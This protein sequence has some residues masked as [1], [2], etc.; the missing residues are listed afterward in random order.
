[1]PLKVSISI[2]KTSRFPQRF[3]RALKAS[4][5]AALIPA[6]KALENEARRQIASEG[7]RLGTPWRQLRP[8]TVRAR[9][10]HL[11]YYK[12]AGTF[13][14]PRHPIGVWTG[15]LRSVGLG[16]GRISR[17]NLTASRTYLGGK[18]A[19]RIPSQRLF[20]LHSGTGRQVARPVFVMRSGNAM[21]RETVG[22]FKRA[23]SRAFQIEIGR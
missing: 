15:L 10:K 8:V 14:G 9:T 5:A 22:A 6:D 2:P 21:V 3:T 17:T 11:R 18:S 1:M 23:F 12:R 4:S 16:N 7:T 13:A 20:Y 19:E